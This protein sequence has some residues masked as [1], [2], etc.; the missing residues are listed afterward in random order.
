MST[1]YFSSQ[2]PGNAA[3][4]ELLLLASK[5]HLMEDDRQEIVTLI[6]KI[7]HWELLAQ[8]A[9]GTHLA[10][11]LYK[12]LGGYEELIPQKVQSLLSNSY[13]QV[14]V[15]NIRLYDSFGTM[16]RNLNKAKI[17]CVPL[18]GIYLVEKVYRDLGLRH[19][20]DIDILIRSKDVDAMLVLMKE[21][22]WTVKKAEPRS[23]FEKEEF[24]PAHPYTF[25]QNGV[26]IELHTHLYNRNEGAKISEEELWTFT[27]Q[28]DFCLGVIQQ[29]GPEMLL[30]HLCLHLHKHLDGNELK[31]LNFCD[32]HEF[33]KTHKTS[34]DWYY[35]RTT[36]EK[37]DGLNEVSEILWICSKYW[38]TEIPDSFFLNFNANAALETK[39]LRFL[40]GESAKIAQKTQYTVS[41]SMDQLKQLEGLLPKLTFI[42]GYVFPRPVFMYK[43][44]NLKEGSWLF[45]WYVLRVFILSQK[46][47]LATISK[48][49]NQFR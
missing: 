38:K 39:F 47:I 22:G 49:R 30:Q 27:H 33:I 3:V 42:L 25:F 20:S 15:R 12:N 36:C 14:L 34:F 32:I 7:K 37:Y 21:D 17:D 40:T 24:S 1:S 8:R 41:R 6:S 16:L 5:L 9:A 10:P 11:I 48:I 44:F 29:F 46:M 4:Y 23:E 18:K 28:E 45:P 43:H 2:S 31:V 19:L 35:F 26:T 13:N